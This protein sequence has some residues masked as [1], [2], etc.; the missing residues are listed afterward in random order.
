M[1]LTRNDV[2]AKRVRRDVEV[3]RGPAGEA[4]DAQGGGAGVGVGQAQ[5]V[6]HVQRAGNSYKILHDISIA[7]P[8]SLGRV[9]HHQLPEVLLENAHGKRHAPSVD[10]EAAGHFG[11]SHDGIL[12]CLAILVGLLFAH[13]AI[14]M[15]ISGGGCFCCGCC[16]RRHWVGGTSAAAGAMDACDIEGGGQILQ[17]RKAAY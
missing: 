4:A 10:D 12:C 6:R 8:Q 7:F 1:P 15:P 13:A 3:K 11:A 16:C 2:A 17:N 9:G 14:V 5:H